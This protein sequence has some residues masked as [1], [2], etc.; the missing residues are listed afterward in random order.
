MKYL[1]FVQ[2]IVEELRKNPSGL[3]WIELKSFLDLPYPIPCQTWIAKMEHENGLIREKGS[4]R[5]LIWKVRN[6]KNQT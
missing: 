6:S 3:T 5:A 1:E 2:S 4:S